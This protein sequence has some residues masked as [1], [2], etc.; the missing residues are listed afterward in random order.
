MSY[1]RTKPQNGY[2]NKSNS[3]RV[4]SESLKAPRSAPALFE[5]IIK[6]LFKRVMLLSVGTT[7]KYSKLMVGVQ[8]L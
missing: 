3:S 2:Y 6:R 8:I 7:Y 4:Q 5:E 1:L